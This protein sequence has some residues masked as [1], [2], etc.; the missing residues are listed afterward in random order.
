MARVFS[1][2]AVSLLLSPAALGAPRATGQ[3]VNFPFT[4]GFGTSFSAISATVLAA[5]L[6]F[7][8]NASTAWVAI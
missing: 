4:Y 3:I 1:V 6:P 5:T 2:L 8:N 7:P